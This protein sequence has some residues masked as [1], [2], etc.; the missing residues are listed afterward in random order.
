VL[1]HLQLTGT[2]RVRRWPYPLTDEVYSDRFLSRWFSSARRVRQR[3]APKLGLKA[4]RP[5]PPDAAVGSGVRCADGALDRVLLAPG[6]GQ[7]GA[8]GY[9]AVLR[10]DG[11]AGRSAGQCEF[12]C[13]QLPGQGQARDRQPRTLTAPTSL[14]A[15]QYAVRDDPPSAPPAASMAGAGPSF[16]LVGEP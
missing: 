1:L 5:C 10:A 16:D 2:A 12:L 15:A 14:I 9:G 7:A 11:S 6:H 8:P 4:G 13:G 3:R